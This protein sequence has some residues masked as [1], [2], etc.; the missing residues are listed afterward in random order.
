M[1]LY[2]TKPLRLFIIVALMGL[3]YPVNAA[4]STAEI[5]ALY[6]QGNVEQAYQLAQQLAPTKEGDPAFDFLFGR[7]AMDNGEYGQGVFALERVLLSSPNNTRARFELARGYYQLG[8]YDLAEQKLTELA[9]QTQLPDRIKTRIQNYRKAI[10]NKQRR[11]KTTASSFAEFR[12]GYDTNVNSATTNDTYFSPAFGAGTLSSA[13]LAKKASYLQMNV[14]GRVTHPLDKNR[15]LFAYA[16]LNHRRNGNHTGYDIDAFRI[17][18]GIQFKGDKQNLR[19]IGNAQYTQLDHNTYRYLGN[20]TLELQHHLNNHQR[21][22][23]YIQGGSI[24]YPNTLNRDVYNYSA[25]LG[26]SHYFDHPLRPKLS[27]MLFTTNYQPRDNNSTAAAVADKRAVGLA[28]SGTLKPESDSSLKLS[29]VL[30]NTAY[31]GQNSTFLINRST[32]FYALR[33]QYSKALNESLSLKLGANYSEADSNISIY[34][35]AKKQFY[36]GL[37]YDYQ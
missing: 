7:I 35:Y 30:Q 6:R 27:G 13:S 25:G 12:L 10:K 24:L 23:G 36:I 11:Y 8:L 18:G 28:L 3:H 5:E 1:A 32:D 34:D 29:L 15:Q 4:P 2:L 14:G 33:L 16:S 37:R 22:T 20:V 9:T 26:L 31:Q 17:R 21:F 19:L